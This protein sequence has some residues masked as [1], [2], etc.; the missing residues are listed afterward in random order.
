MSDPTP[1]SEAVGEEERMAFRARPVEN[2][3]VAAKAVGGV[4]VPLALVYFFPK[5]V[6]EGDHS[7]EYYRESNENVFFNL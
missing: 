3:A 4:V 1:T 5:P 6:L 2:L 7:F